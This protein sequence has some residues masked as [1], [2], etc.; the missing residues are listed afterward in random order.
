MKLTNMIG[1]ASTVGGL[2]SNNFRRSRFAKPGKQGIWAKELPS[3]INNYGIQRDN[4][5]II[6]CPVPKVMRDRFNQTYSENL[7]GVTRRSESF[8]IPGKTIQ[9]SETRR[10]GVGP[11]SRMPVGSVNPYTLTI[12]FVAD[13]MGLYYQYWQA[14]M[15]G[16]VRTQGR[17]R[18]SVSTPNNWG[19]HF[20]EVEYFNNYTVDITLLE[21]DP[22]Y[23]EAVETKLIN[24]YPIGIQDHVINWG[25]SGFVTFNVEFA[26][27]AI[28][29]KTDK[30]LSGG[31]LPPPPNVSRSSLVSNLIKAGNAVQ[32]L[33]SMKSSGGLKG[34]A[35]IIGVGA[36][37]LAN[38]GGVRR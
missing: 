38:F 5:G 15:D 10:Y 11:T 21:L 3:H 23:D 9:T 24:A 12:N 22:K 29:V 13:Q 35:G 33:S 17:S 7:L 26:V 30:I 31:K 14:W 18:S 8:N 6:I 2:L 25:N 32:L 19:T 20:F 4:L 37:A 16:I 34:A 27:E 36:A 1:V 28:D